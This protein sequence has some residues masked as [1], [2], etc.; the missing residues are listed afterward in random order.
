[1]N[2]INTE[3]YICVLLDDRYELLDI[4]GEGGMAVVYKALDHRLDRNVAVKLMRD[5]F[6]GDEEFRQRFA[7]ES[8][9]VAM[10][11]HPNIVS[12]FDVSHNDEIEYIVME[13][14][15]GITLRQYMAKKGRLD[16]KEVLHFSKQIAAAVSHAHQHGIIHRDIKPQNIMLLQDGTIKVTDFGIAALENELNENSGEAVGSLCFLAPEQLMGSAPDA[17][18][19][20]Y[21]LGVSMYE[22]L[23]AQKPYEGSNPAELRI[24][25]INADVPAVSQIVDNVPD[26]LSDIVMKAM[27]TDISRRYQTAAELQSDLDEFTSDYIRTESSERQIPVAMPEIKPPLKLSGKARRSS[28]RKAGRIGFALGTFGLMSAV[29]VLFVFLWNFWLRDIFSAADRVELPNFVGYS[30]DVLANDVQLCS[31][32]NFR[33]KYIVDTKNESGLVLDQEPDAGRSLMITPEGIDVQLSVST[34]YIL[35]EVPDVVGLDYREASLKLQNAGFVAEI[36]NVMSDTVEKNLVI[37]SSPT[38]GERIS[39]G[40][41]VYI[42]VSGGAEISYIKMPN[43][44]GLSEDAAIKKLEAAGLTYNGSTRQPSDYEAGTVISQSVVAFVEMEERTKVSLI[45]STGPLPEV[46]EEPVTTPPITIYV[47]QQQPGIIIG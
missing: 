3:N 8:H 9:A 42:D 12:V 6:S 41:T 18:S 35:A 24:K 4:I 30:Y 44:V 26:A 46:E 7:A 11:S 15:S 13:L 5:E 29:L 17:R 43:L 27:D 45:V 40:S 16:W 37:S 39:A 21:S 36:D 34:G 10:L 14:I 23:C 19:D 38:A 1:M 28:N 25:Q 20:I 32:Y 31:R 22:M 47:P 2:S 33:V